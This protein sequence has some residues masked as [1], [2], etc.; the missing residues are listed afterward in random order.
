MSNP[1]GISTAKSAW[2]LE[3]RDLPS[4]SIT[5]AIGV[6]EDLMGRRTVLLGRVP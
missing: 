1:E 6:Y 3:S 4:V 5:V 2:R